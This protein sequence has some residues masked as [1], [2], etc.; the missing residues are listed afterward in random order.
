MDKDKPQTQTCQNR[1][2]ESTERVIWSPPN[3]RKFSIIL[4]NEK[5]SLQG[6]NSLP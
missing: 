3:L 2:S 4:L 6:Y 1:V 5:N